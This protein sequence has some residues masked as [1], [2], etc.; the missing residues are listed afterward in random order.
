MRK[1]VGGSEGG[2]YMYAVALI[3]TLIGLHCIC[4]IILFTRYHSSGAH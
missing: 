1:G 4:I 3:E 2:E